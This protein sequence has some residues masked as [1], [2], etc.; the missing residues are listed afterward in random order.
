LAD[1]WSLN[2]VLVFS[3]ELG[4]VSFSSQETQT[5]G[6]WRTWCSLNVIF[7]VV[8]IT[9]WVMWV[10]Q[11]EKTNNPVF[12]KLKL[13]SNSPSLAEGAW[14]PSHVPQLLHTFCPA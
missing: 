12:Q 10:F 4:F 13:M 11:P 5:G 14:C 8:P 3:Y 7:L 6:T 9:F 1:T 2:K